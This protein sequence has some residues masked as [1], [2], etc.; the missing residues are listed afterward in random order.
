MKKIYQKPVFTKR[1]RLSSVT[2]SPSSSG[3]ID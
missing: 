2:A 3:I 1:E